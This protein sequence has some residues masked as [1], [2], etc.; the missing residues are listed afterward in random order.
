MTA[1][2]AGEFQRRKAHEAARVAAKE[3][4]L[5]QGAR[6]QAYSAAAQAEATKPLLW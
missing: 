4:E 5:R 6:V 2:V 1:R 3:E